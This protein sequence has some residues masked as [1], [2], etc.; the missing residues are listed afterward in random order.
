MSRNRK[1]LLVVFIVVSLFGMWA[2]Y[3]NQQREKRKREEL[4]RQLSLNRPRP[5][6]SSAPAEPP[7]PKPVDPRPVLD[8]TLPQETLDLVRQKVGRD[9]RLMEVSFGETLITYTLSTDGAA[10]QQYQVDKDTKEVTGPAPVNII[11]GG[12]VADSLFDPKLADLSLIPRLAREAVER[13]GLPEG[14]A[15]R[16]SFRYAGLRYAGEKPEWTVAVYSGSGESLQSKLVQFDEKGKF[17][18]AF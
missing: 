5:S 17:K 12:S 4:F 3:A 13:A 6:E 2:R 14:H 15:D 16:V 10:V 1:I 8:S 7:A 9:F 18:R 11:G